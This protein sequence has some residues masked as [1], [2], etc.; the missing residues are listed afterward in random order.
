MQNTKI[1]IVFKHTIDENGKIMIN[2]S[3]RSLARLGVT[4]DNYELSENTF[5]Q[6]ILILRKKN[7]I[8]EL[9]FSVLKIMN[10]YCEID[11]IITNYETL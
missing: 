4:F 1:I 7:N 9:P 10:S 11:S 6:Q 5:G 2:F 3:I 8:I